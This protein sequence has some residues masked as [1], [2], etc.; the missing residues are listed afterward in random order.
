MKHSLT[1]AW[2]LL[3]LSSCSGIFGNQDDERRISGVYVLERVDG[4][5]VPA[6]I[7]PQ[8]GCNRTVRD[9]VL[10]ISAGGSD[11]R[12]MYDWS[13]A[14]DTNCDPVPP[15]VFQGTDD[16]GGWSFASPRLLFTSMK[17]QGDYGVTLEEADGNP[18]AVTFDYLGNSYRFVRLMRFDDPQ[19]VVYVKFVDQSGQPVAGVGLMFTFA[20]GLKGGG[21]TPETG[22]YGAGGVVGECR[23]TIIAPSG[24]D[25]PAS[26]PNP[27]TVSIVQS[28]TLHVQV[29]LTKL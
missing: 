23:I 2:S 20:N 22:E 27:F 3:A 14:I 9:G 21:T 18:P 12:P 10:T 17:G 5:A 26:Q 4:A 13:F 19:G 6:S 24:Y 1:F 16:A 8:E 11:L 7:A 28:P 25:V 29:V 15:S